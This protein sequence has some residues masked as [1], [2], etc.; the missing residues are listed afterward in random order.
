M[1]SVIVVV[2]IVVA[3]GI[4]NVWLLRRGRPTAFRGGDAKNMEEEFAVYGLS[5]GAMV[6]IGVLKIACAVALIAG[7]FIPS[8]TR[9]AAIV[10]GV[11][12]LGAVA[13][14]VKVRDP[15]RKSLPAAVMLLL[16]GLI[17]VA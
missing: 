9:P 2:Q 10:L 6:A 11:L 17:A 15:L 1:S 13:M 7:V 3:L 8:L 12:M 5:K 16:C 14:H 4:L